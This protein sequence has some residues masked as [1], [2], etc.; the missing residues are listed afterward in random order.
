MGLVL[1]RPAE[2]LGA[3]A[4]YHELVAGAERALSQSGRGVL[5]QVV[6]TRGEELDSYR[7][8]AADGRVD[9][10]I[11]V[12][13]SPDDPR[14]SLVQE[15][16]LPAV[17]IADPS[18]SAG[19]GTVWT[20]D[21]L[22]MEIAV[23][24]LAGL[25]HERLAH[26]SGPEAM[27]HTRIRAAAFDATLAELGLTGVRIASDYAREGGRDAVVRLLEAEPPTAIVFDNDLMA[28][29]GLEACR[30]RGIVVPSQLSLLAWD[31]SALAQLA[32]PSLSAM[33]HDVQKVG[34]LAA[35]A[36]LA[37]IAGSEPEVVATRHPEL[38]VRGSTGPL[39]HL[40]K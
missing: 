24:Y 21:D 4:Y 8:W 20:Q 26:V 12:D 36:V 19:L 18:S 33:S 34:D 35:K 27:A 2:I 22:A 23:R 10:V 7:R 9:G 32:E 11:L 30:S 6:P 29:G 28:L 17:A 5:L 40:D 25:G 1:A 13:L 16:G 3:E 39:A 38:V 31:D 15:L 37:A 14:T